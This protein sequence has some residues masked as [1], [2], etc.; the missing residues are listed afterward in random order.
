M[1]ESVRE[2]PKQGDTSPTPD[3]P[4]LMAEIRERID[5][6]S[7]LLK[8]AGVRPRTP[9][10]LFGGFQHFEGMWREYVLASYLARVQG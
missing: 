6:S 2:L 10:S 1:S 8:Q 3:I 9:A 5:G 7:P 4:A